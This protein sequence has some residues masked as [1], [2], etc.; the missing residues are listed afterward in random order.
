MTGAAGR[1]RKQ[2]A[3]RGEDRRGRLPATPKGPATRRYNPEDTRTRIL[4]SAYQ[5]FATH[6]YSMTGTADIAAQA[7]VSEGSIFYHFGSKHSLLVE[8]GRLHGQKLVATMQAD[9]HP[10]ALTLGISLGRCFDFF[11]A[12][13][14]RRE[15][16]DNCS[17]GARR[18]GPPGPEAEPFF[19]AAREIVVAWTKLHL[20]ARR[21][22]TA[23]D[24]SLTAQLVFAVVAEAMRQCYAPGSTEAE[25]RQIRAECVRFCAAAVGES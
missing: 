4:E 5:L 12:N 14:G 11:E 25:R 13:H 7:G 16:A 2:L 10:E 23:G 22:V 8:L 9:D 21:T 17:G 6:G 18:P 15:N 3:A 19:E 1:D 24:S 20:D